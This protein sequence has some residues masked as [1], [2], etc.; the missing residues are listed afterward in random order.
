MKG[1]RGP[2]SLD[3][4]QI[5]NQEQLYWILLEQN[6]I[7][8]HINQNF[9]LFVLFVNFIASGIILINID[10]SNLKWNTSFKKYFA[11]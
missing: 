4:R 6:I 1:A 5:I 9:V 2:E 3:T 8:S 7:F 11:V 10:I